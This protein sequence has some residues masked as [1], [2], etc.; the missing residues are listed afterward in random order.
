MGV[1]TRAVRVREWRNGA[2]RED[3]TEWYAQDKAGIVWYFGE[4][5]NNYEDG[6]VIHHT[7]SWQAGVNGAKP[8]ILMRADPKVGDSYRQ[9]YYKE[10]AEAMGTV[11]A[12]DRKITVP[13]G[14]FERCIQTKD[15]SPLAVIA[16]YKY[17]CP[18]IAFMVREETFY[19]GEADLIGVSSSRDIEART[20][21]GMGSAGLAPELFEFVRRR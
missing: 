16:E 13:Y 20:G 9:E 21:P 18:G 2:L 10:H 8:G 17:Y 4:A 14:T 11:I 19:G 1:T 7:G 3:T 6:K 12:T 15:T 5:V